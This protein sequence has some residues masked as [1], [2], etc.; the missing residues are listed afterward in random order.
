MAHDELKNSV[1]GD[2]HHILT[3]GIA[4]GVFK[5]QIDVIPFDIDLNIF[6]FAVR[7]GGLRYLFHLLKLAGHP[8][9]KLPSLRQRKKSKHGC[10]SHPFIEQ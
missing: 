10:A 5:H 9:D 6:Q 1:S 8:T 4:G 2:R 7:G 3:A